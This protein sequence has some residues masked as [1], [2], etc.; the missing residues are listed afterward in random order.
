MS[1]LVTGAFFIILT[2]FLE[3][4]SNTRAICIYIGACTMA[5]GIDEVDSKRKK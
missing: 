3:I 5:S 1:K 2:I 4:D